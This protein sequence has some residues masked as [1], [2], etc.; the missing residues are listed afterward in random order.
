MIFIR[1]SDI[2]REHIRSYKISGWSQSIRISNNNNDYWCTSSNIATNGPYIHIIWDENQDSSDNSGKG[3]CY[4]RSLNCGNSWDE[5]KYLSFPFDSIS[6]DIVTLNNYVHVVFTSHLNNNTQ[7][8]YRRSLNNGTTWEHINSNLTDLG[9][10]NLNIIAFKNYIHIVFDYRDESK[11]IWKIVYL[12]SKDNGLTWEKSRYLM[13]GT[14]ITNNLRVNL[15]VVEKNIYIVYWGINNTI[16]L[17]YSYNNGDIWQKKQISKGPNVAFPNIAGEKDFIGIA[18]IDSSNISH[19]QLKFTLS[20]DKGKNWNQPK[21]INDPDENLWVG[22]M[23]I[24]MTMKNDIFHIVWT[25]SRDWPKE[26][27]TSFTEIYYKKSTN[28]GNSWN[29]DIRLTNK[30]IKGSSSWEPSISVDKNSAYV[31]WLDERIDRMQPFFIRTLPDF[32]IQNIT[33]N[34]SEFIWA[35]SSVKMNIFLDNI[36]YAEGYLANIS[37]EYLNK[38]IFSEQLYCI[39]LNETKKISF[40]W[41]PIYGGSNE[42]R[43]T[44]DE[45]NINQEWNENNN[46]LIKDFFIEEN[47]AP[48]ANLNINKNEAK[49]SENIIFDA[50]ESSD[51]DG[52]VESYFFDFGD[53]NYSG[54]INSSKIN[55]NY[56]QAGSYLSKLKV[57]DNYKAEST[58]KIEEM[59]IIEWNELPPLIKNVNIYPSNPTCNEN[60]TISVEAIDLNL[61][62]LDYHYIVENG[63]ING[64]KEN[65]TWLTPNEP[66]IYEIIIR[67]FDG[68]FYSSNWTQYISVHKNHAPVIEYI[69]YSSNLIKPGQ[70]MN[71]TII[72]FDIDGDKLEYHYKSDFGEIVGNGSSIVWKSPQTEGIYIIN[73]TV[74]DGHGGVNNTSVF[75]LAGKQ[76]LESLIK[77]FKVIPDKIL[78]N[79]A[80]ELLIELEIDKKYLGIIKQVIVNISNLN[81]NSNQDLF[82]NGQNGDRTGNDGTF[83]YEFKIKIHDNVE[84]YQ[85]WANIKTEFPNLEINIS[86]IL[87]IED[88][89]EKNN[90][91]NYIYYSIIILIIL[92]IILILLFIKKIKKNK[93]GSNH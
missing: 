49:I 87:I 9:G 6:N 8:C 71:L 50:R 76:N 42:L 72:A 24:S 84:K 30:D 88:D 83:S 37:V 35:N 15:E 7:I 51:S 14:G 62:S 41:I 44:I 56:S 31:C 40:N 92:T 54:W 58:N 45:E 70:S 68:T 2:N 73:I 85:I 81:G 59:I 10:T 48:I 74:E 28:F 47:S 86:A 38:Q 21:L 17:I 52:F 13:N 43:I 29:E 57:R 4:R 19:P 77:S 25:D 23:P 67:V 64:S 55:Y 32:R 65:V 66:G 63:I 16:E 5:I 93:K 36:G 33:S 53:G 79:K 3:L 34:T 89:S 60:V 12:R 1:S 46:E 39:E 69:N 26:S 27:S 91:L 82:D 80:V 78:R 90:D 22:L 11:Q 18:W 75:I 61:D 20:K